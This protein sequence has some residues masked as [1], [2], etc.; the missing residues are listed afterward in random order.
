MRPAMLRPQGDAIGVLTHDFPDT[1]V[2]RAA[3]C[4]VYDIGQNAGCVN[5]GM[6]SDTAEF[7]VESIRQWWKHMGRPRYPR[8]RRLL[9]CADSGGSSE[10][11]LE[12]WKR[13]L[14]AFATEQ[15]LA[16]TVCHFPPGTSKWNEIEHRLFSFIT[17]NWS[18]QPLTDCRTIVNLIAGTETQA[19]L[20][21]KAR[22]DRRIYQRGIKVSAHE[23]K[24]LELEPHPYTASGITPSNHS[25]LRRNSLSYYFTNPTG[26]LCR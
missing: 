7:A 15:G 19:G 12:M 24:A 8:A 18:G 9:I 26:P 22:L 20:T 6:S 23:A 17:M 11:H 14:R 13:E 5:V 4:G 1:E 25:G 21:V 16:I 2:R 3:P 10:Y